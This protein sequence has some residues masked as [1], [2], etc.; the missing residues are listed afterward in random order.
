MLYGVTCKLYTDVMIVYWWCCTINVLNVRSGSTL[1]YLCLDNPL[2]TLP[3]QDP[4]SQAQHKWLVKYSSVPWAVVWSP[5]VD[6]SIWW[7]FPLQTQFQLMH[8]CFSFCLITLYMT[9]GLIFSL[10]ELIYSLAQAFT[11]SSTKASSGV[12]ENV[13]PHN[14]LYCCGK[15][16]SL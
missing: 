9:L 1:S 13:H 10:T 8:V 14:R 3:S 11:L 7:H 12:R 16:Y 15:F 6:I 4:A 5:T 2:L